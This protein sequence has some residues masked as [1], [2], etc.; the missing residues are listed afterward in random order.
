MCG[1]FVCARHPLP[2]RHATPEV[3]V[4]HRPRPRL[5]S[6][7]PPLPRDVRG[8]FCE[9]QRW[10]QAA[11][12]AV[13]RRALPWPAALT[14]VVQ[15]LSHPPTAETLAYTRS[16]RPISVLL[17]CACRLPPTCPSVALTGTH[18]PTS[19]SVLSK[20]RPTRYSG[21]LPAVF[22]SAAFSHSLSAVTLDLPAGC[23]LAEQYGCTTDLA[24]LLFSRFASCL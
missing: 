2:H 4:L 18:S 22:H 10:R 17:S 9:R 11:A 1:H 19:A 13:C 3:C 15:A 24:A 21:T 14:A 8:C 7:T 23:R 12:P 6:S 16:R 5:E 20:R